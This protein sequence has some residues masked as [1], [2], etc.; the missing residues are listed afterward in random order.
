MFIYKRRMYVPVMKAS[1]FVVVFSIHHLM[2]MFTENNA[3]DID[4]WSVLK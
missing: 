1:N 2:M 4:N 3:G